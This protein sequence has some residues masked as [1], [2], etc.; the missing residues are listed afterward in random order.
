MSL[1][2]I[3]KFVIKDQQSTSLSLTVVNITERSPASGSQ[4]LQPNTRKLMIRSGIGVRTRRFKFRE[5]AVIT[6]IAGND[7]KPECHDE[8]NI[9][10]VI[11]DS[12]RDIRA[13]R[14]PLA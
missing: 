13:C 9:T 2:D 3:D 12:G 5:Q 6:V 4:R 10:Y 14:P 11:F 1:E 7:H 8:W